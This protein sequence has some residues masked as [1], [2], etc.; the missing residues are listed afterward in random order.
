MTDGGCD[1][2]VMDSS[3]PGVGGLSLAEDKLISVAFRHRVKR[4]SGSWV[5][6]TSN[7]SRAVLDAWREEGFFFFQLANQKQDQNRQQMLV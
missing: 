4:V 1:P 7:I 6:Q 5:A 2:A 3:W